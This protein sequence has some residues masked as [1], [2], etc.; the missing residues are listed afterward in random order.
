MLESESAVG[1]VIVTVSVAVQLLSS[2]TVTVYVPIGNEPMSW[3]VDVAAS[4]QL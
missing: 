1:S 4:F 3:V 2:V